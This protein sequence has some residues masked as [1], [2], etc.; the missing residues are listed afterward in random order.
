[1]QSNLSV[2][3]VEHCPLWAEDSSVG[4]AVTRAWNELSGNYNRKQAPDVFYPSGSSIN[5]CFEQYRY[6]TMLLHTVIHTYVT[7]VL[8]IYDLQIYVT[9]L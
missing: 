9:Y 7:Q 8:H 4:S 5:T 6:V 1:M 2:G 3:A